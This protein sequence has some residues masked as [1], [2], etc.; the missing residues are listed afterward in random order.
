MLKAASE[1][2]VLSLDMTAETQNVTAPAAE[3]CP[4]PLK[5]PNLEDDDIIAVK[6]LKEHLWIGEKQEVTGAEIMITCGALSIFCLHVCEF[7]EDLPVPSTQ[8]TLPGLSRRGRPRSEV[9]QTERARR[10]QAARRK[11][12]Q[13]KPLS[14]EID[15]LLL[16]A[17]KTAASKRE[18]TLRGAVESALRNWIKLTDPNVASEK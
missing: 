2:P 3:I 5:R 8:P 16:S 13:R 9:S 17:F 14:V 15:P 7:S 18:E 1:H 4:E 6:A 12:G 10:Y 11:T